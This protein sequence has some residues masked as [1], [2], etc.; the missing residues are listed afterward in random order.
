M[1]VQRDTNVQI[2]EAKQQ[3]AIMNN[4]ITKIEDKLNNM[5]HH[6]DTLQAIF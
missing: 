5:T 1:N 3:M 6:I 4:D 2:N